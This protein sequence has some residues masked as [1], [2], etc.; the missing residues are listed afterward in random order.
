ME[1]GSFCL[2]NRARVINVISCHPTVR[3]VSEG[4]CRN[5]PLVGLLEL[6]TIGLRAGLYSIARRSA[7]I[8]STRPIRALPAP[9]FLC[10]RSYHRHLILRSSDGAEPSP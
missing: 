2:I 9:V 10:G 7:H 3:E 6:P 4:D 8:S 1:E 5:T